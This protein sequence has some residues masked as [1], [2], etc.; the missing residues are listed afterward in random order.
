MP[1]FWLCCWRARLLLSLKRAELPRRAPAAAIRCP[2]RARPS[3]PRKRQAVTT[4]VIQIRRLPVPRHNRNL[5]YRRFWAGAL[6][7][8]IATTVRR[9][10]PR[11]NRA[12][13][14]S[15]RWF[16]QKAPRNR[17]FWLRRPARRLR[18]IQT[19]PRR[20][21]AQQRTTKTK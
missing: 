6:A 12:K 11:S 21:P 16:R 5:S 1:L 19:Q 2:R 20:P 15:L 3:R 7:P 18:Q 13:A 4:G 9:S 17:R 8:A 14:K 10:N